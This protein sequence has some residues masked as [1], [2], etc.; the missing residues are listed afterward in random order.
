MATADSSPPVG[1]PAATRR[2]HSAASARVVGGAWIASPAVSPSAQSL[3]SSAVVGRPGASVADGSERD[4]DRRQILGEDPPHPHVEIARPVLAAVLVAQ[5]GEVVL[6]RAPD[7]GRDRDE[8]DRR[9]D[10]DHADELPATREQPGRAARQRRDRQRRC[11]ASG[12]CRTRS[13]KQI[14]AGP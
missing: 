8:R 7:E 4:P 5:L 9:H 2:A 14:S 13:Q 1:S 6:E 10:R 12:A 11:A 3:A